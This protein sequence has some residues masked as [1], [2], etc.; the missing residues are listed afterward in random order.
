MS[1]KSIYLDN[2]AATPMDDSVQRSMQPYFS[3]MFYNPS[4]LY[5][6]A[7][8]VAHHMS[9]ARHNIAMM[10]GVR[11]A[12]IVFTAG[13]SEANNLAISG[14]MQSFPD[15]HIVVSAVEHDS[16]LKPSQRYNHSIAPVHVDGRIQLNEL[17]E[18]ITDNT[19][20]VS[21]M[22]ANN[23]LG[24][25]MPLRSVA[26]I[27]EEVKKNR[28]KKNI[29]LPIFLHTDACQAPL[30]L[31]VHANRL[32]ADLVTLNGSK[33]YGPK[34]TGI[35]YVKT[36]VQV[37]PIIH[38]GGQEWNL[39]SGTENVPGIIGFNTALTNAVKNQDKSN[40]ELKV[41]QNYFIE[42]IKLIS[43]NAVINGSVAYRLPNNVHVTFPGVDNERL[44]MELDEQGIMCA[45][46]SACSASSDEPSHVLKAIGL[47]DADAQA[48]LRFSMS[49]HTTKVDINHTLKI[50]KKLITT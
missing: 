7:K 22:Y 16:V 43:G 32:G 3:D 17:R 33:M 48:S 27:I 11:P 25:V 31:D 50:L 2:A 30:Y 19:V 24:T 35:L 39:R 1:K 38:G 12:E 13:G 44:M 14:V 10:L 4:A 21:V 36:G 37:S 29:E 46:G 34:Q 5:L 6:K 28:I 26:K 49:K 18:L 42:G 9:D 47:S 23:E 8:Q 41:L 20:L 40:N 45:V 15:K